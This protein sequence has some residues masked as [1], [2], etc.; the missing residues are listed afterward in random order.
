MIEHSVRRLVAQ[1]V[2]VRVVDNWSTDDTVARVEA[3]GLGDRVQ[4]ERFPAAGPSAT[5]DWATPLRNTERIAA[6]LG[7]G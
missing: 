5:Y 7:D 3:L 6:E 2:E 1:G 4:V